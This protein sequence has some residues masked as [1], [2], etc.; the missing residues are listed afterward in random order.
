MTNQCTYCGL[1]LE[2]V[3]AEVSGIGDEEEN[4]QTLSDPEDMC[5]CST[6]LPP[7]D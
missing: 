7:T 4:W 5:Q 3:I 1:L 2:P 6:D